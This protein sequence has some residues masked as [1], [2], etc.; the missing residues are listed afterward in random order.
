MNGRELA[1]AI[2][3]TRPTLRV[4]YASGYTDDVELLRQ[5][6]ENTVHFLQKPFTP[7][8]LGAMVRAV[9]DAPSESA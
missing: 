4:L 7:T 5:L 6:R 3:K 9:L 2:H 1:E 8:T